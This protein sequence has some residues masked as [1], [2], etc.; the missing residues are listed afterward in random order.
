VLA[1]L[2]LALAGA[3]ASPGPDDAPPRVELQ[4]I[5]R[6]E[7]DDAAWPVLDDLA[8]GDVVRVRVTG[9]EPGRVGGVAQCATSCW[10]RFPVTFDDEGVAVFQY[11]LD[12]AGCEPD[13]SCTLRI[14]V[15]DRSAVA[16]TV[17]GGP[18]P[19][20]PSATVEPPGP[21][22]PGA[23]VTVTVEGLAPGAPVRATYCRRSCEGGPTGVA[24]ADGELALDVR[25][26]ERCRGCRI[27]VVAGS[28]RVVLPVSFVAAPAPQ[29]DPARL[30]AGLLLAVVLLVVACRLVVTTDWRPPAEAAVPDPDDTG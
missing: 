28:A 25:V 14:A 27:A 17:F 1:L 21:V 18:A 9:G 13:S 8:D 23:V 15:E 19:P 7:S 11:E 22:E 5:P 3:L 30:A 29:Y 26:G 12:R 6:D 20:A 4:A 24:G 16:F 10:N 2:A